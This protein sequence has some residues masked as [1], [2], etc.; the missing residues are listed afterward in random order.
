MWRRLSRFVVGDHGAAVVDDRIVGGQQQQQ[1]QQHRSRQTMRSAP[2]HRP[3]AGAL[4][5]GTAVEGINA[6]LPWV[7]EI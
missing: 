5:A 2:R 6:Q 4:D 7:Q 1:Q 3:L